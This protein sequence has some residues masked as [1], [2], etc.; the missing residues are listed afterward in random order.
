MKRALVVSLAIAFGL[1]LFAWARWLRVP[2]F[3][4][5]KVSGQIVHETLEVEGRTRSLFAYVPEALPASPALVFV[6]H[7]SVGDG[8]AARSSY[9]HAFEPV[10]DRE[11]FIVVYPD[12]YER[13]WN[14]CRAAGPY[15]ANT[16][17]VD[18]IAFIDATIAL[19][20]ERFGVDRRRV[21]ATGLSNGGHM[22][23]R[24]ALEAPDRIAAVAPVAAS[25]PTDENLACEKSGRAA[26]VLVVNGTADPMNPYEGGE[27][28]L[29]GVF[30]SR[31]DVLSSEETVAYFAG[32]AGH[33]GPPRIR[34]YPDVAPEDGSTAQLRL[35]T[36]GA[37]PPV[38]LLR[39]E[40]GGHNV[41]NPR[42]R[43][44][45]FLGPTNADIDAAE[46]IW[47]FFARAA[48]ER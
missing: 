27:A 9:Y 6:L 33:S 7:G 30:A 42:F 12:G 43:F 40:N 15:A 17:D 44:P 20:A 48:P 28:A 45:L 23:L 5:P 26:A 39:L 41:P 38:G 19:F 13:H 3:E 16:E 31:G 32:L 24:L 46:E 22:A 10:A 11:G 4:P 47:R 18:D 36:D 2:A 37:G 25:L 8:E 34:D 1:L 35:W 21:F 29:W 14:G